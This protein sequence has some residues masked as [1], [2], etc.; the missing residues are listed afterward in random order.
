VRDGCWLRPCP[1]P[2]YSGCSFH[3]SPRLCGRSRE[4]RNAPN[5]D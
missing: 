4:V 1:W 2:W 3:A 5:P